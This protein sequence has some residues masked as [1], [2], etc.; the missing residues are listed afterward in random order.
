MPKKLGVNLDHIAT[1]REARKTIEPD[2]VQAVT[3]AES[4]GAD[5]ITI[6]LRE[7]R[8]HI[9][10]RDLRLMREI[11]K[12][13]LNL[14]MA[15]IDEMVTIASDIKPDQ[16]TLVPEKREEVTTEGGLCV[17]EQFG[18]LKNIVEGLNRINI[19]VSLFI[20]PHNEQIKAAGETGTKFVEINTASYSEAEGEDALISE[21]EK[22]CR[23]VKLSSDIGLRVNAGHGLTYRN[24]ELLAKLKEIEEFN[25]G[26]NIIARAVFVGLYK[27]VKEMKR[28]L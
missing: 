12:T 4:A 5:G 11:V 27:A 23:A 15:P 20:D 14:E 1:V 18:R 28:L 16:V 24:I 26:H 7:D 19:Q 3:L 8:R 10:D 22:I 21:Y 25:I 9:N 2:P 6:H 13:R 17:T